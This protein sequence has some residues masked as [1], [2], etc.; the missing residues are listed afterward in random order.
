MANVANIAPASKSTS[1]PGSGT[2]AT[3]AAGE[4]ITPAAIPAVAVGSKMKVP[5]APTVRL[6]PAGKAEAVVTMSVPSATVVPPL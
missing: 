1:V 5:S 4:A 6:L 3:P 2:A